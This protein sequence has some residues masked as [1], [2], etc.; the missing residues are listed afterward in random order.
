[1]DILIECKELEEIINHVS[2]FIYENTLHMPPEGT[3][4]FQE[5]M[6]LNVNLDFSSVIMFSV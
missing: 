2:P 3:Y 4:I 5:L 1:V 6:A